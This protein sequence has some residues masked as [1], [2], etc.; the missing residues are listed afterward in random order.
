MSKFRHMLVV[1][2]TGIVICGLAQGT[3][4]ATV[5]GY[6]Q[7]NEKV[8]GS[9]APVGDT[10]VDSSANGHNGA[11]TASALGYVAGAPGY[12]GAALAFGNAG[13]VE[14]PGRGARIK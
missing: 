14:I 3:A 11:V 5:I 13:Y 7:F 8:P 2:I 10:I 1:S 9:A 6:W 12:D 4:F